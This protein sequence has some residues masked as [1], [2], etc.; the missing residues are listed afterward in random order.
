MAVACVSAIALAR[1]SPLRRTVAL[2]WAFVLVTTLCYAGYQRYRDWWYLRFLLP[3]FGALFALAAV[4]LV[5]IGSA[6]RR[7]WG[8]AIAIGVFTILTWQSVAFAARLEM[9][10]PFQQSEHKYADVGVF[11]GRHMPEDA[12]FFA[13]QHSG[14]IRYY[15]GRHTVRYDLLGDVDAAG[16]ARDIERLGL[17]PYLAIEDA[18]GPDVKHAFGLPPDAP[19]PWP[20]VARLNRFGGFSILDLGSRPPSSAPVEI[21]TGVAPRCSPPVAVSIRPR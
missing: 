14:S 6:V 19:L 5:T 18:E 17:H 10:G 13:M 3:G 12:V 2:A 7:P 9:Y 1:P 21:E 20:Y 15:G 16:A 4:A 11:I 8:P